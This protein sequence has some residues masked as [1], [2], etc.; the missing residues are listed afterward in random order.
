MRLFSFGNVFRSARLF[1]R[2]AGSFGAERLS[3]ANGGDRMNLLYSNPLFG[4]VIAAVVVTAGCQSP[5]SIPEYTESFVYVGTYTND[6]GAKGIYLYRMNL[7]T[8]ELTDLGLAAESKSPSFLA[9]HPGGKHL[10]A[11]NEHSD[12]VSAFAID[13][14]SGKLGFLNQHSSRGANPCHLSIDHSGKTVLV[15][16]YS[17]GSVAALPIDEDG[18]LRPASAYMKHDGQAIEK[19]GPHAHSIYVDP[20]NRFA[21]APDVG[22]DE[23]L[24]YRFDAKVGSLEASSPRGIGTPKRAGPRHFAFHPDGNYAYVITETSNTMI[25]YEYDS[26]RGGLTPIQTVP[27]VPADFTGDSWT[28]EIQVH[29]SGRFV[30]GSNRGHNSIAVYSI[31]PSNGRLTFVEFEPTQ[32][33][34]PRGF[35]IDPTGRFFLAGNRETNTIVPF[36]I[37]QKTGALDPTGNVI[38]VPR[39]VCIKFLPIVAIEQ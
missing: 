24:V 34:M 14:S 20:Q 22:L 29:P 5:S 38:S 26:E 21:V 10:Y 1:G 9:I 35:G 27:T 4:A 39:P 25:A 30:Y 32:G 3:P 33:R 2:V 17:G 16:N 18:R 28:S 37:D 36:T 15:A 19:A 11:V 13:Q 23:I 31:D 7:T 8:G 6:A 12:A